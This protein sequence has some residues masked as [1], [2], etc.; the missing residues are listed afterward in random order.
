MK[1]LQ[2]PSRFTSLLK[3][4]SQLSLE[5]H[6]KPPISGTEF[7]L[8]RTQNPRS[9]ATVTGNEVSSEKLNVKRT[10][11]GF[12]ITPTIR[13]LA[14]EAMLDYFYSTRG[15][16]YMVAES[17]SKNSPMFIDNLLKK[18]DCVTA[19]DINQSI[20]RYLRFHPVNEFEPFLE[21]S[22]LKP[23]EYS[24]LVPC[25]K[26]FLEEEGFLLENHHVLC[27]SGVD[28]KKI[29]KIFK[30]AREVFGYETG[31]LASKIKA[32]EDL[33]FSRYF[34]SKLIVCS[35]RILIGNTNVELAKVL[36]TLK[37]MGFE[38]D[39]VMENLSDEG[40]CDWSSVHRVLRLFR[41][42]CF[43]EEELCGLIRKYPRLVFENSGKWT[44]ILVGFETKLGSSRRELCSLF[45]KFPLIQ[46]EKCVSNLRQC[47]LFLKEIEMED[48]EIHKV[49]RSHSWWLGSCRLKKTSSLLVFLKAGKT[50]VCQV[51]QES[52][53]EMKKWT[54]GSK[55]QP[56]PATNVDIDSKLMKTQFL[57][58]LGYKEN[59]EEMESALKNFRGKRS[60]LRERFNVLVSLGF[61][62]KD[63]KDMVKACPT[64]LSQ[65][66]DIL[67]SKVNYL[68]NELGYPHSTLVDFPSCLKF[69]LQRMKLRFAMFSWLQAR[70]KVDRKIKVSTMLACSDKIF[71][72]MSFMRNPR[73]KSL[74][75]WVSQAFTET[76]FK[77]QVSG[78]N[79][80][81]FATQRAL[82]DAEV[83]GEKWGLRTRNEIRKVAQ[84]AMF[85]Y[86]YQ[87]RGLQFLVA[88]SMSRNAPVFNDNLLKKLNGCDVDDDDDVVKAITRFLWF[89]PVNEFEPFLESLGLKPSEFSHLIPCDKMFLNEDA[90]L[91]ENYHVFW[92]YGIGREKMGKIFKEA[93]EV[94]GY[95]TGVLA[96]K[97]KAYEDLGFSKLFLSKLIVCSP[98]ILIGNTNVGLA[99]IMEML[100]AISFGVDWVTE[101][102]SEEVSYDWSS[103]HRCLSF[104]RDM[105][106]D[107]NELRELIRKRPKL[108]FEDSGEW[109]MI[110]AGFE[111]K[112]GSSRSELSSLFQKFPQSQSI[113]KFVSNLRHCFLFLKD[114]DMEADEIGKIFRLHSSWL[115][116]TRLK[117]TS[118]LLIN[119]K[120]GKGR[121]CQVIQENPE[122]MKKWIMGLRVQP[123]PATGCK[124][125]TKS[126]TMKTQFLLDLGYKENS[127]EM[128]RALKNF[129]GKGSELRERFNV[130]VSFGF[131][132]KD[133]KDMV[134]A[135]PSILSQ[136]C[137]ILE[138][139]VNYLINELGHPLLTLVTFPTCLKYTLQRMKLRF[140]MFSWLQDRGKADPKLAV[141][142]ILVCS[143]KFFAT[144]F[145]NRHPDGAKHLEDLKKLFLCQQR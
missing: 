11:N 89:H 2:N 101:N 24:H 73:F 143:D 13:K 38:F 96:S 98:S 41:E 34:L 145:V 57:L 116:V 14:E 114:I 15:L 80:R 72:I 62:E 125:D 54:M 88:E 5:T 68:I 78:G 113:G 63:V 119:L 110:L 138:S 12:R 83:S 86:F 105:C 53:E 77:P 85:D 120:G 30:E 100:K 134:K 70:G 22:G 131:T 136:A 75:N 90:F 29:G 133:V 137:D 1:L 76:P 66:C 33:G 56:L 39:W 17:M 74:L 20:T 107:E 65:T 104:L 91:L 128:E 36:K 45:Q 52:P 51:I 126:K 9:F 99:K 94:F 42:I 59:S 6:L 31:V 4:V 124:V 46:V 44:V 50:R 3:W 67:E 8:R 58:D 69:T 141:S 32:Y 144:R 23:T 43:D 40:S 127:E 121:L 142:T 37:S 123:L 10:R 84:V 47:F 140:A 112:L 82:V 132:E 118:T 79:P 87:T 81:S 35:P 95:E 122:E 92:N 117:Q 139:K 25:D 108:I 7:L 16:Q 115:G 60:E 97:I 49:F 93:R 130:L 109:T 18:V 103:M 55:I 61:T 111:A 71:V 106:V 28:P 21:S 135:C 19:S 27:Y 102:L 129:R 48:D 26:V 64:M